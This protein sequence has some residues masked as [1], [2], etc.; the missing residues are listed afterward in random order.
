[1]KKVRHNKGNHFYP[2]PGFKGYFISKVTSDILCTVSDLPSILKQTPNSL[3][4]DNYF[5]VTINGKS[6]FVHRL[7]AKTFLPGEK[8]HVNH[9][10]GNKQNNSLENLEWAT[11]KENAHH[12]L[13]LGLYR[14]D[15]CNKEV[16]QYTLG[17][18]YIQSFKSDVEAFNNTKVHKQNISKCTLG[19]RRHA[20]GYQ[21]LRTKHE[22]IPAVPDK[23][24]KYFKLTTPE[25]EDIISYPKGDNYYHELVVL[26]GNICTATI[27]TAFKKA[28]SDVCFIRGHRLERV[29][30]D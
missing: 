23:V 20:G 22:Y 15:V 2:I 18:K 27:S 16:H 29:F 25:G 17:G 9:I 26:L 11:P 10:D 28:K 6:E 19:K 21:W 13:D 5:L 30:F 4:K 3:G 1:M 14:L 8:E 12:A 24:L 7:M